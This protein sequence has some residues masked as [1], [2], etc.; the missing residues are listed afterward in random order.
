MLFLAQKQKN[1]QFVVELMQP[2]GPSFEV[3]DLFKR[4][5]IRPQ[6]VFRQEQQFLLE[7]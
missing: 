1:H 5:P 7:P 4:G 3:L 2:F 6:I